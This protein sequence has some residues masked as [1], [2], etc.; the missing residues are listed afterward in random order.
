MSED[1]AHYRV[2]DGHAVGRV[3][4]L[5]TVCLFSPTGSFSRTGTSLG[6]FLT[7]TPSPLTA[8]PVPICKEMQ[9]GLWSLR[10]KIFHSGCCLD[11]PSFTA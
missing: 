3:R 9:G 2:C 1:T 11:A 10:S 4:G 7:E 6:H 5:Q 8:F